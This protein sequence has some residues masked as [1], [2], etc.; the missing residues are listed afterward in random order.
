MCQP[1]TQEVGRA[2][3]AVLCVV[4]STPHQCLSPQEEE[5]GQSVQVSSAK[6]SLPTAWPQGPHL[7]QHPLLR[8]LPVMMVEA[9]I[10]CCRMSLVVHEAEKRVLGVGGGSSSLPTA[11]L[12]EQPRKRGLQDNRPGEDVAVSSS[13]RATVRQGSFCSPARVGAAQAKEGRWGREG[14][15]PSE[16]R[17]GSSPSMAH[18]RSSVRG[19]R[20]L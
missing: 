7:C 2:S 15:G 5:Q 18:G 6:T 3:Q 20:S 10:T 12:E 1:A 13:G 14:A 16:C 4:P 17:P 9:S 11:S 19:G 8:T